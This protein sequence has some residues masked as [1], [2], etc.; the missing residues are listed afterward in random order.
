ME[1]YTQWVKQGRSYRAKPQ[2][3]Y[4]VP[5]C[6]NQKN[7]KCSLKISI[8]KNKLVAWGDAQIKTI[9][10]INGC[11]TLFMRV[12]WRRGR[13]ESHIPE[14]VLVEDIVSDPS[15]FSKPTKPNPLQDVDHVKISTVVET[16]L[17]P[18][19]VQHVDKILFSAEPT[20][21]EDDILDLVSK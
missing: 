2:S 1:I 5:R 8:R 21:Q 12:W 9:T 15:H 20:V 19:P 3:P 6:I 11:P 18:E 14:T 4:F 17:K 10:S 13:Y 16:V 7:G